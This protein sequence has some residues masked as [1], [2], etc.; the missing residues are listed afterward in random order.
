MKGHDPLIPGSPQ[1]E[2]RQRRWRHNAHLG[3]LARAKLAMIA[4]HQGTTTTEDSKALAVKIENLLDLLANS[5]K[6][7][8]D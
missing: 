5:L 6:Y 4:I 2:S 7:R 8:K 3:S 1:F